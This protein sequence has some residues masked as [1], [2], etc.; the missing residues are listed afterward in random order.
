MAR[1]MQGRHNR[2]LVVDR[3]QPKPLAVGIRVGIAILIG[4]AA[5]SLV[6][7]AVAIWLGTR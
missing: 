3:I 7:L 5:L 1:S 4:I 6:A 2:C